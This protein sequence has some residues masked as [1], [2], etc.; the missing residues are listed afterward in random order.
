MFLLPLTAGKGGPFECATYCTKFTR[1][2]NLWKRGSERRGWIAFKVSRAMLNAGV[3][4]VP[5]AMRRYA[6]RSDTCCQM[7]IVALQPRHDSDVGS[8][9]HCVKVAKPRG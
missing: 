1:R 4:S 6:L 3:L 2:I 5:A 9:W 7:Y 8:A